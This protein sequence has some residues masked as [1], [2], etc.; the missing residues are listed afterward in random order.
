MN[1]PVEGL[2]TLLAAAARFNPH[3]VSDSPHGVAEPDFFFYEKTREAQAALRGTLGLVAS[4][5]LPIH[6]ALLLLWAGT[7]A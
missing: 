5:L 1:P 2:G 7:I 4:Q 6:C 3:G